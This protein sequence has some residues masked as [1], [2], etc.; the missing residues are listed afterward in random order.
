MAE[1][2]LPGILKIIPKFPF[3]FGVFIICPQLG[4]I[5]LLWDVWILEGGEKAHWLD[6][7]AHV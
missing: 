3:D 1:A 2:K 5:F 4:L 6:F 7:Q